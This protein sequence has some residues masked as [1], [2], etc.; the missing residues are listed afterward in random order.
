MTAQPLPISCYIRTLNEQR[1]LGE[2]IAAARQVCDDV[3]IVDSGS[4]DDT[5]A[6]AEA[7]GATVF[8]QAWLGNGGQKRFGEDHCKHDWVLD[9]DADEVVTPELAASIRARFADGPPPQP[10]QQMIMVIAPPVGKP[11]KAF[12]HVPRRKL[13]DRRAIRIPD[14]KAWDQ[15]DVPPGMAVGKLDGLLLH[16]AFRDLAHLA[17][18]MNRV[19]TV[20]TAESKLKSELQCALRVFLA[21]PFYFARHYL[22]RG[23][24][25]GGVYGAAVAGVLVHGRWLRDAKMWERHRL[26]R[27]RREAA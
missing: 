21:P 6:I 4:T 5:I 11:W 14:H 12:Y 20:R 16:Y 17:Q 2:V 13:Y 7:A 9:L 27:Q 26:E 8:H 25:R 10:V 23:L 3:V 24:W 15:F 19:S 18:K 22:M 1:R